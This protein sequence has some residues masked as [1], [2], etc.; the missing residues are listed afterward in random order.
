[1]V[2]RLA[3]LTSGAWDKIT[4]GTKGLIK[5][6]AE[7]IGSGTGKFIEAVR[8]GYRKGSGEPPKSEKGGLIK[9]QP[10]TRHI[11]IK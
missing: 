8:R 7:G 9:R 5:G 6:T 4:S 10:L 1:M 2:S 11:L 3:S